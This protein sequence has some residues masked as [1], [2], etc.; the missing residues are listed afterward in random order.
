MKGVLILGAAA[1][2]VATPLAAQIS[3]SASGFSDAPTQ[4]DKTEYW[5]MMNEMG[6]CVAANKG[7][8]ARQFVGSVIDSTGE[9]EAFDRLFHPQ[10]NPCMRNFVMA[11]MLR[12]HARGVIA[13]GLFERLPDDAL[14]VRLG[15]M[16][17]EQA[18]IATL[19]DFA[20]CYA[21]A[22][23]SQAVALLKST[24]VATRGELDFVRTMAPDFASCLPTGRELKLKPTSV[25]FA[26][27]EA[28]Y[29]LATGAPVATIEKAS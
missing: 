4:A 12:S 16:P 28:L 6:A 2:V 24:R 20:R 5:L 3:S 1:L 25:R 22:N 17:V 7:E 8:Q 9:A 23:P 29:R 26:L 10:R 15:A 18:A 19:H 14:S 13:E 27:A 21:T 11:G